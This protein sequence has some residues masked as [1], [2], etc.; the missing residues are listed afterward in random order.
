[1]TARTGERLRAL[2]LR[3][4][5]SPPPSA[6]YVRAVRTGQLVFL[7]G[8]GPRRDGREVYLG[9]V[10]RDLDAPAARAAARL[11]ALN[12]LASLAA[13]VGDLDRVRRVVA[14]RGWVNAAPGFDRLVE[15]VDGAS[16]LIVQVF[17]DA[18]R[19]ARTAVGVNVLPGNVAVEVDAIFEVR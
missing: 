8:H 15:V 14:L 18:G 4:P 5:V 10:G 12:A 19:H 1:V 3:L 16:D 11:A 7:A 9:A 6:S 13:E 2:G 17:G